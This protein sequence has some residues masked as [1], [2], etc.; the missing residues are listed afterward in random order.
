MK[1]NMCVQSLYPCSFK[2]CP[3][4]GAMTYKQHRAHKTNC[5]N[6]AGLSG[7]QARQVVNFR[8]EAEGM[9]DCVNNIM[10]RDI[11]DKNSVIR[12]TNIY[13]SDLYSQARSIIQTVI[14]NAVWC[15]TIK[16]WQ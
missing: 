15:K 10:A 1:K 16:E 5:D 14:N 13:I 9:Q 2:Y 7:S 8:A 3:N 12:D 11:D 4:N 6:K